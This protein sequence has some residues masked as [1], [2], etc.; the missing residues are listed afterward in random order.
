MWVYTHVVYAFLALIDFKYFMI[1]RNE[2]ECKIIGTLDIYKSITYKNMIRNMSSA[3]RLIRL[4]VAAIIG[5]LY[6]TGIVTG[7]LG[8]ALLILGGIFVLTGL[9]SFCPIY[10]GFGFRT[11]KEEEN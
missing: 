8:T 4:I 6:F 11:F 9:R 10:Y 5:T 2:L 7:I 3:D 1:S